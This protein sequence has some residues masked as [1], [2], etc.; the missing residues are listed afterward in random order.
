MSACVSKSSLVSAS[1]FLSDINKY[2]KNSDGILAPTSFE[3]VGKGEL[4]AKVNTKR[5]EQESKEKTFGES[6]TS[7][8]LKELQKKHAEELKKYE[9]K[10]VQN[11]I[12]ID[13]SIFDN[14][15]PEFVGLTTIL[16]GKRLTSDKNAFTRSLF[17][18]YGYDFKPSVDLFIKAYLATIPE[19]KSTFSIKLFNSIFG[20]YKIE[21][22]R[23]MS[24]TRHVAHMEGI[25]KNYFK[26][27]SL[28]KVI[29]LIIKA[30]VKDQSLATLIIN[31]YKKEDDVWYFRDQHKKTIVDILKDINGCKTFY[32]ILSKYDKEV[33]TQEN[34][35]K[36]VSKSKELDDI[37]EKA[38]C[39]NPTFEEF[40][41]K[42][43]S[44][45][46]SL[47]KLDI[48]PSVKQIKD[49]SVVVKKFDSDF[50]KKIKSILPF[51]ISK[52]VKAKIEHCIIN[53]VEPKV[54]EREFEIQI[55]EKSKKE[56][57]VEIIRDMNE[58][59]LEEFNSEVVNIDTFDKFVVLDKSVNKSER[60]AYGIR[61]IHYLIEQIR[62]IQIN[63][64]GS[65]KI[66]VYIE[67]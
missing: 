10:L 15:D 40:L 4:K 67:Y 17:Q 41:K 43:V 24:V 39:V 60:L 53:N 50:S 33:M 20:K 34:V 30:D 29:E 31:N 32:E 12:V 54:V 51:K 55:L 37:V 66:V 21:S 44:T 14:D 26:G 28:D 61:L 58:F 57:K 48:K 19:I 42:Y 1:N 16:E 7:S 5:T 2:A 45:L 25:V 27:N 47:R 56:K 52:Q 62:L 35:D 8:E 18:K 23:E 9:T 64:K 36:F 13:K 49:K 22:G 63:N 11:H 46:R 65:D 3:I 6:H 59:I 38:M